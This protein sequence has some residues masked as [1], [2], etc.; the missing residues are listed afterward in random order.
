ML[1]S[2]LLK[3]RDIKLLSVGVNTR[4]NCIALYKMLRHFT[5]V[6][7]S[8]FSSRISSIITASW[9]L[10]NWFISSFKILILSFR[11][12]ACKKFSSLIA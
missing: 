4:M 2:R 10:D 9:I 3:T 12:S 7:E 8:F 11:L 6:V 1:T 5:I